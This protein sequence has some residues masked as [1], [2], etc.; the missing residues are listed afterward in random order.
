MNKAN[1]D[2]GLQSYLIEANKHS[3]KYLFELDEINNDLA[4]VGLRI[5]D[6]LAAE[7]LL[8]IYTELCIGLAKH[9]VKK[10]QTVSTNEA[11]QA[12]QLLHSDGLLSA[13][14]LVEWKKIIGMRNGLVHDY[15]NID[16]LIVENIIQQKKYM[17]LS[18]FV[19]KAISY[20][21]N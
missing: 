7:R 10:I 11:Y 1:D 12:F 14:D 18:E 21:K 2:I 17:T 8:Q 16:L 13:N 19:A 5:R 20:L 4:S 3:I 15:L 6:Y 9:C